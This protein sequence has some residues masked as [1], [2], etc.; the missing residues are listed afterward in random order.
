MPI[1]LENVLK[2]LI[3]IGI[4]RDLVYTGVLLFR[5][6]SKKMWTGTKTK[7]AR[8][9]EKSPLACVTHC[10]WSNKKPTEQE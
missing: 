8:H 9:K 2:C 7:L 3:T 6:F 5:N 1:G 4:G 10:Q